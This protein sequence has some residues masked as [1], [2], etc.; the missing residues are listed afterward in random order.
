VVDDFGRQTGTISAQRKRCKPWARPRHR[1]WYR[2]LGNVSLGNSYYV[3]QMDSQWLTTRHDGSD[4]AEEHP[5]SRVIG[6]DLSPIQ[7]SLYESSSLLWKH[8]NST[9]LLL[10]L[11]FRP[12]SNF[13]STMLPNH[14]HST[15]P[16]TIFIAA[17]WTP[18]FKT[19][20]STSEGVT[21]K[22]TV[23]IIPV[24]EWSN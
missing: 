23:Y 13:I 24:M 1:H 10:V 11:A 4:F 9:C 15:S 16:L 19:G 8:Q 14:G 12:W 21:S 18:L 5:K 22:S 6:T 3:L 7:P 20:P 2:H 17:L